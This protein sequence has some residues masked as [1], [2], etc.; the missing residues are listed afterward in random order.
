MHMMGVC[1]VTLLH[2][3]SHQRGPGGWTEALAVLPI[4]VLHGASLIANNSA[5]VH[6]GVAFV[7]MVGANI[8]FIIFILELCR[9]KSAND[10]LCTVSVLL[11]CAGSISCVSGEM[12]P[13]W[14][15]FLLTSLSAVLGSIRFVWQH[16]L[17]KI[18]LAPM[19]MVFWNGFWTLLIT[20]PMIAWKERNQ[21][22]S[23]FEASR[24][25]KISLMMSVLMAT[26][27]NIS[28]WLALKRLGALLQSIIG[29]LNL[30]LVIALSQFYLH[31][32]VTNSQYL[33]VMLLGLG[34]FMNK[35]R[36]LAQ[37][38]ELEVLSSKPLTPRPM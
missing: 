16:D 24:S 32:R 27:L 36:D 15:A 35:A 29:N 28:Q 18:S 22:G 37:K 17:V 19:R 11:V 6:G 7:S 26:V 23:L 14:A 30:I 3:L 9:G 1:L 21:L 38:P 20:I 8:P 12:S 4:S 10:F 13:S 5:L 2:E 31:E 33:G 25:V 34:T